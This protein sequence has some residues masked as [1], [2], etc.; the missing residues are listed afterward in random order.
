MLNFALPNDNYSPAVLPKLA[1]YSSVSRHVAVNFRVPKINIRLR[2]LGGAAVFV[3]MPETAVNENRC[4]IARQNYVRR[5]REFSWVQAKPIA[6]GVEKPT[7]REFRRRAT[8]PHP[9]HELTS[10]ARV[11]DVS[12]VK[13]HNNA[14]RPR[15]SREVDIGHVN[16]PAGYRIVRKFL[17]AASD[18]E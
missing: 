11:E 8:R 1:G 10:P 4:A 18:P 17:I 3:T 14:T 7:Y 6:L 5:S 2:T 15:S 16:S 13:F 9:S 12:H